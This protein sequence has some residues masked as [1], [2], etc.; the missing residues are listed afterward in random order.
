MNAPLLNNCDRLRAFR[1]VKLYGQFTLYLSFR[2]GGE[3]R[4]QFDSWES[5]WPYLSR[6]D[7]PAIRR[8]EILEPG[9][10]V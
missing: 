1:I 7:V 9:V 10:D 8:A 6:F 5:I 2:S 3:V 4:K